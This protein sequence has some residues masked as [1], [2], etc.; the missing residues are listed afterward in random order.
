MAA[1]HLKT[2]EFDKFIQD[3]PLCLVDFWASW[4]GPCRMLGP[5]IEEISEEEYKAG[6][7]KRKAAAQA[8]KARRAELEQYII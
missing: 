3:N 2:N 5:T 4:C 1:I 8:K 7:A 6:L